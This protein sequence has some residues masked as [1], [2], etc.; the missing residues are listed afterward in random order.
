LGRTEGSSFCCARFATNFPKTI[1]YQNG[2]IYC[3][4]KKIIYGKKLKDSLGRSHPIKRKIIVE[5]DYCGK[6]SKEKSYVK[7]Y[8]EQK[9]HFCNAS[10]SQRYIFENRKIKLIC[11]YFC[12]LCD[13]VFMFHKNSFKRHLFKKH[14]VDID[15]IEFIKKVIECAIDLTPNEIY[16]KYILNNILPKCK[17]GCGEDILFSRR[18]KGFIA[19]HSGRVHNNWGHNSKALAKSQEVRR[20]MHKNGEIKIW[21]KGLTKE[22]DERVRAYGQKISKSFTESK[23]TKYSK[24]MRDNRLNGTIPTLYG[25]EH[26]QWNGGVSALATMSC[27]SKRLYREWKLP[28]LSRDKF[29]CQICGK[30]KNL[31]V[32]HDVIGMSDI[33]RE[34]VKNLNIKITDP[35]NVPH[36]TKTIIKEG[37]IQHHIDHNI[38]GITLCQDCHKKEHPSLN[39]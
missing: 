13:E 35:K 2:G 32:H 23:R 25:P 5:C 9:H 29:S 34:V 31:H 28:I 21:H 24:Q 19:G 30:T 33:V 20:Q 3:V 38:S 8:A 17:C 18:S 11:I 39:F 7:K 16:N 22:T 6:L 14:N 1:F 10:C 26:S 4:I 12:P 36:E 27:S 37:V 15:N